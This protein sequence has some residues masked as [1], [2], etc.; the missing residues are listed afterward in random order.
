MK[1]KTTLLI[2]LAILGLI[3]IGAG[4]WFLLNPAGGVQFA[5]S[6]PITVKLPDTP[7]IISEKLEYIMQGE[8]DHLYI[9]SDVSVIYI[10]EKGLLMPMPDHP[11]TG[12]G[13]W[14]NCHKMN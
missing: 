10:E 9:Y 6:A 5:D 4:I 1:N 14:E 12:P 3:A 2:G 8:F 7:P 13:N 11:P